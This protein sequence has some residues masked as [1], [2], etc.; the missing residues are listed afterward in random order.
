MGTLKHTEF[1]DLKCLLCNASN[2]EGELHFICIC[3][4][5]TEFRV[6]MFHI[7]S[8]YDYVILN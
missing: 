2:I 4:A 7:D 8:G 6:E 5:H 1:I 3:N